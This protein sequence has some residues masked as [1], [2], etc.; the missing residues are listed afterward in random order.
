MWVRLSSIQHVSIRGKQ[1]TYRSGDCV[2]VGK[3][4][5]LRWIA[6]G[7]ALPVNPDR[8]GGFFPPGSGIVIWG[9]DD[10]SVGAL[11]P[12]APHVKIEHAEQP[13]LS[14]S[15][16]V[17]WNTRANLRVSLLP[18][19]LNTLK[20]WQ[21]AVPLWDYDTLAADVS[22]Q[23]DR[24]RT[25][26]VI[27]D[28]RVPLYNVGLMFWRRSP[29]TERLMSLWL[30]EMSDGGDARLAFLRA[31]YTV[32]PFILPLPITWTSTGGKDPYAD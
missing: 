8:T 7:L 13:R 21:L 4:Q 10:D 26:S 28:L 32:K 18:V 20:P 12:I 3:Q 5:A 23:R 30:D 29:D 9:G 2:D 14:F 27:R 19:G 22:D 31:L 25:K 11:E 6:D 17:I 15:Q 1:R 24:A 16:T